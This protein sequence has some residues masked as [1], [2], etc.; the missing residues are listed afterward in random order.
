VVVHDVPLLAETANAASRGY[1]A[2]LVVEAPREIRLQRLEVRGVPREDAE[3]RMASQ[4]TDEMR[5]EIATHVIDN[6][7]DREALAAIVDEL[8]EDL[9]RLRDERADD[10]DPA[11][12]DAEGTSGA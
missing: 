8:W 4:A 11:H 1:A 6:G 9:L 10:A 7:S 2:V 12:T 3:A 5:R